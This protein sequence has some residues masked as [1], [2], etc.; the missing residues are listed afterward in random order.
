MENCPECRSAFVPHHIV[1]KFQCAKVTIEQQARAESLQSENT[2]AFV[3]VQTLPNTECFVAVA[4][5]K[6]VYS[7]P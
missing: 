3:S 4:T 5:K 6:I 2:A 7:P 1:S